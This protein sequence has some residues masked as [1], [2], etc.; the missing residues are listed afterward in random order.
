M[1]AKDE[2]ESEAEVKE[3]EG[4]GGRGCGRSARGLWQ[5]L[6]LRHGPAAALQ[7]YSFTTKN[8]GTAAC[9]VLIFT[10]RKYCRHCQRLD[11]PQI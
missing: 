1:L 3:D 8:A 11:H 5:Q 9:K 6:R 4:R 2:E 10:T 7:F